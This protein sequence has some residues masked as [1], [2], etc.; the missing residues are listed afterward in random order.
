MRTWNHVARKFPGGGHAVSVAGNQI[1]RAV[2]HGYGYALR[3]H[4]GQFSS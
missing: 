2:C 3:A 4:G 1:F